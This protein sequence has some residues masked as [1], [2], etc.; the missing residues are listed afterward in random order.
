LDLQ[1]MLLLAYRWMMPH[2]LLVPK[3]RA[4]LFMNETNC[5]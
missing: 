3:K 1:H 5:K 2:H 4:L